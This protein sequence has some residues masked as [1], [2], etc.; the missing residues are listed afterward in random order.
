MQN[1]KVSFL[2]AK[3]FSPHIDNFLLS[4]S[5]TK[6]RNILFLWVGLFVLRASLQDYRGNHAGRGHKAPFPLDE[7]SVPSQLDLQTLG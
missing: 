4:L 2:H 1:S 3:P 7:F 6:E 5:K